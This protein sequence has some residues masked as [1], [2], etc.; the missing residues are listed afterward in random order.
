MSVVRPRSFK[1][2]LQLGLSVFFH[3]R[4]GSKLLIQIFSSFGLCASYNDT[5]MYEAAAVLYHPPFILPP[6]TGTF[7]QYVADNADI[8]VNSLDGNN[9]LHI[10]GII[11]T[12]TP[13]GSVSQEDHI[14]RIKEIPS[15][16]DI[17]SKTHVPIQIY[18]NDGVVGYSK[19]SVQNLAYESEAPICLIQ[20]VEAIWFYGK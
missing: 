17:A 11:Q 6:Q 5:L 2:K 10:M 16:K 18:Q 3:R 7:I 14:P 20:K 15:E 13:K 1:S 19:I 9:S 12:V 8:N 4:F